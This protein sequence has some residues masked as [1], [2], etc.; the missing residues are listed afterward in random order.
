MKPINSAPLNR[1]ITV[2]AQQLLFGI[3]FGPVH[4]AQAYFDAQS[5]CWIADF[6]DIDGTARKMP[7]YVHGWIA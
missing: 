2:A 4:H 7:L 5:K 3:G 1:K 6:K